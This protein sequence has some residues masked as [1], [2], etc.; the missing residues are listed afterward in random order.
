[1]DNEF[2]NNISLLN[3]EETVQLKKCNGP[4]SGTN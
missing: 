1:M 2:N 4:N 3:K